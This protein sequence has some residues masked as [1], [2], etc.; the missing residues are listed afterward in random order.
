[1]SG[2][3][4]PF[5]TAPA[6]DGGVLIVAHGSPSD[7][8]PQEEALRDLAARVAAQAPGLRVGGTTLAAPGAFEKAVADLDRPL[9]YPFFMAKGW[10]VRKPLAERAQ[11]FGLH[12]LPPFGLEPELD[13]A[14]ADAITATLD[15]QGWAARETGLFVAAHGSAVSQKNAETTRALAARL[16]LRLGMGRVATGFVEQ[17]PRLETAARDL[18]QALCLPFFALRSGH[19]S[20][21][22]PR[23]LDAAGFTGPVLPPF[24]EWPAT[25]RLIARSL[26]A[27]ATPAEAMR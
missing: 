1:M 13:A 6:T 11:P 15:R 17:E 12:I 20:D 4:S 19:Y 16:A 23:A 9:I 26:A 2:T 21:D 5:P 18:G 25:A 14:V 27:R 10:F 3:R 22:L 24:I 8:A 7:P